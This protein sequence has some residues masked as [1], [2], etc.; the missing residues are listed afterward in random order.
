[1]VSSQ[2]LGEVLQSA[3]DGE[4]ISEVNVH[5]NSVEVEI[6][7]TDK[8]IGKLVDCSI[9]L[10]TLGELSASTT[11]SIDSTSALES[12]NSLETNNNYIPMGSVNS[13][14]INTETAN[15]LEAACSEDSTT[16]PFV[17]VLTIGQNESDFQMQMPDL[18]MNLART[19]SQEDSS[20]LKRRNSNEIGDE[21]VAKK[22]KHDD[23]KGKIELG[24]RSEV[25]SW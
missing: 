20:A 1:M 9:N 13:V 25:I 19:K 17:E 21:T 22:L 18:L 16:I 6:E 23:N 14:T 2:A 15:A 7:M 3:D 5:R 12:I 8:V 11:A 10:P 4:E 24:T